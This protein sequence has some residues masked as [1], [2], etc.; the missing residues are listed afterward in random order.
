MSRDVLKP[1]IVAA[2]VG[3]DRPPLRRE[4]LRQL[5]QLFAELEGA[6]AGAG[7]EDAVQALEGF[8]GELDVIDELKVE[9]H[10]RAPARARARARSCSQRGRDAGRG[11]GLV[12]E[13]LPVPDRAASAGEKRLRS[14]GKP[15][16]NPQ[17]Y[18]SRSSQ[19]G[20]EGEDCR[21]PGNPSRFARST[22]RADQPL[23]TPMSLISTVGPRRA[24]GAGSAR[25]PARR[26]RT[27]D[28]AHSESCGS[29]SRSERGR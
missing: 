25:D 18:P 13:P 21:P 11:T 17:A 10:A 5:D 1:S 23:T 7:A 8:P 16:Q 15:L 24:T 9:H 3:G 22:H 2:G 27:G 28:G 29:L 4:V 26:S 12:A 6:D 14:S 20:L 19:R